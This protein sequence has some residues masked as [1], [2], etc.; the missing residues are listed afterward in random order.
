M[1]VETECTV[2][3]TGILRRGKKHT[4]QKEGNTTQVCEGND[5]LEENWYVVEIDLRKD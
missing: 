5:R 1:C 3:P 2:M 4:R